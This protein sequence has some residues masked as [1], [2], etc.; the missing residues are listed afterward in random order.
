MMKWRTRVLTSVTLSKK[1][2]NDVKR[3]NHKIEIEAEFNLDADHEKTSN[4]PIYKNGT[5]FQIVYAAIGRHK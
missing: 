4:Y 1:P 2:E 5:I 3:R